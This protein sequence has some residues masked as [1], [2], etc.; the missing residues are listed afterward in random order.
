MIFNRKYLGNIDLY[1]TSFRVGFHYTNER[2]SSNQERGNIIVED[3]VDIAETN[4]GHFVAVG[5]AED[6]VFIN[7]REY[8]RRMAGCNTKTIN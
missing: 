1:D 5:I 3:V 2:Y 4:D 8:S 7:T 6:S